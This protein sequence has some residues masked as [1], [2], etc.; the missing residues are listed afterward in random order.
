MACRVIQAGNK[1]TA[2]TQHWTEGGKLGTAPGCALGHHAANVCVVPRRALTCS[3]KTPR[4]AK[5]EVPGP[6]RH[7]VPEPCPSGKRGLTLL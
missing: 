3:A 1:M 7:R 4:R 5:L 6:P 2:A